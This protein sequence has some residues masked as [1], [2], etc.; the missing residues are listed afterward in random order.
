ML[1]TLY[2]IAIEQTEQCCP[3][4]RTENFTL[5]HNPSQH[6]CHFFNLIRRAAKQYPI[7]MIIHSPQLCSSPLERT[8][9]SYSKHSLALGGE[10][11]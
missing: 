6:S 4:P 2:P 11:F 8:T 5:A 3:Q 9:D 1:S 10:D 7:C